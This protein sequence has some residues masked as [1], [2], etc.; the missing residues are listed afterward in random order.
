MAAFLVDKRDQL[1]VLNDMLEIDKICEFEKFSEHTGF[2]MVLTEAHRFAKNEFYPT[3]QDGD[4]QGCVYDPETHSVLFPECFKKPYEKFKKGG[5]L[6]MCDS[7]EVGGDGFPLTI[8]TAVSEIF[9]ASGFYIYG[10]AELSHAGAKVLEK[11]G[12]Q[13]QKKLYMTRLFSGEWM[14]T[15]CLT[16]PDAGSDVGKVEASAS[17]QSDGTY[18]ITGTKIFITAGE[19]D[20]TENII[21]MVLARV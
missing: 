14:G 1:F 9:Y 13:S 10:A 8:G 6:A 20:L 17:L 21:H 11:Y 5:W 3:L 2:E 4:N 16:E 15:M 7:P 18:A 19:Q 12:T